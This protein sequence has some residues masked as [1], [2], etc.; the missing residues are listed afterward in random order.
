MSELKSFLESA[1]VGV[2]STG[3]GLHIA[4]SFLEAVASAVEGLH[5]I[6]PT[7]SL[8]GIPVVGGATVAGVTL[9]F[10]GPVLGLTG[11]FMALGSGYQE[12]R[13]AIQNDA[14]ASG[15]SQGFV[16][17][18]LNMSGNTVSSIFGRHSVIRRNHMDPEADAL[19]TK[20]YNRGLVAG[21]A[22]ANLASAEQ[23]KSFVF[24]LRPFT[25]NVEAGA[26]GDLEKRNYVI[27][28]AAKL[29]L[30]FLET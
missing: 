4:Q 10:V 8:T 16:A 12:A 7:W 17:G 3:H 1:D 25:G 26:W 20:A 18:I 22:H 9:A 27:E 2:S 29:R 13:E 21:Y 11:T 23:K 24:E 14:V 30:H 15:F 6:T 28:Y 5:L 19:E